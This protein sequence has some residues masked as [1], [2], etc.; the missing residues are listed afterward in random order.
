MR[1]L[2]L[3]MSLAFMALGVSAQE[4]DALQ[5]K[6]I[7]V[8]GDSYVRNH[9]DKIENTWHY[10]FAK[11][12]NMNYYNYGKNGN[13]LTLDLQRWGTGVYRRYVDMK[14]SLDYV[15][16]IGGHNDSSR[17]DSIG[18]DTF[19]SRLAI[20]CKGLIEKYPEAKILFF[21]PWSCDN[22]ETSDRRKVVDAMIE[23]C[24]NYSIPVFD[25]ARKS[26]IFVQSD[27]FR[28][29]YFQGQGKG[30]YAHLNSKG[31]DRFLPVAE[32][33]IMQYVDK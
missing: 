5:G 20:L 9:R 19:K 18:M 30:D 29:I 13:C 17:L 26:N 10:K 25:C 4:G 3:L 16:V 31:H 8:I 2:I 32:S 1:K 14:D 11:K 12:H 21:T 27:K 24:G 22:F 7:G 33:F 6:S 23:V 28:S 15:I